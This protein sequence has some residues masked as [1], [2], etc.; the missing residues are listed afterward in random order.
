MRNGRRKRKSKKERRKERYRKKESRYKRRYD[1]RKE[2]RK[3]RNEEGK[4]GCIIVC[5]EETEPLEMCVTE[6]CG[7]EPYHIEKTIRAR[8]K[9][10]NI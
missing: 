7:I 3:G 10:N 8:I 5:S 4:G 6:M 2:R 9:K 1:I